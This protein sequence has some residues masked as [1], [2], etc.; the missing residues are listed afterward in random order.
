MKDIKAILADHDVSEDTAA[1]IAAEVRANYKTVAEWTKKVDRI[2]E[3]ERQNA[4]LSE[5]ASKVD[6]TTAEITALQEQVEA[7]KKAEAD[8]KAAEAEQAKRDE[9][10]A[11]FDE[12]L[13]DREFANSIIRDSVFERS[14]AECSKNVATSAKDAIE[15]AVKDVENVWM[16]PQRD[17][18]R[19]P[20]DDQM[21]TGRKSA[22]SQRKSFADALFG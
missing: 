20:T 11:A 8:R 9:F 21:K 15:A 1:A 16:N 3:L 14:Y 4:E 22:E 19:M 12:A 2:A 13:G 18:H 5:A 17:P 10:R 6:G 7:M